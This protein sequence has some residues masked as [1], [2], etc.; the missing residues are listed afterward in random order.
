MDVC[1]IKVTQNL[2]PLNSYFTPSWDLLTTNIRAVIAGRYWH[3]SQS[4][5]N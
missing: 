3:T 1:L 2:I 5:N 4:G